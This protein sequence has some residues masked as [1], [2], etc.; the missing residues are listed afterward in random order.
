MKV[1][2]DPK[3]KGRHEH[4]K[5]DHYEIEKDGGLSVDGRRYPTQKEAVDSARSRAITLFYVPG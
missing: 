2:I 5:I 1:Y 3:P 4:E